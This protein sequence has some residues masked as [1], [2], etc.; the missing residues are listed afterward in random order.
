MTPRKA[1]KV[2]Q[3]PRYVVVQCKVSVVGTSLMVLGA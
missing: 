1:S 2:V 3:G